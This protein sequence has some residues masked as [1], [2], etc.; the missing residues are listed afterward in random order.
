MTLGPVI[1]VAIG[2]IMTFAVMALVVS[3]VY[4]ALS[5]FFQTRS[6]NLRDGIGAL[7]NDPTFSGLAGRLFTHAAVHPLGD[8][9]PLD[10]Q[11]KGTLPTFVAPMQFAQALVEVIQT[12]D[13]VGKL[14][15]KDAIDR[16][17]DPQIKTFLSGVYA[18][19]DG[20]AARFHQEL[21]GWFDGAMERVRDNFKRNSQKWTFLIA[22]ILAVALN[23]DAFHMARAIWASPELVAQVKPLV[24]DNTKAMEDLA[25]L[26]AAGLPM[27]WSEVELGRLMAG[28]G[29][30]WLAWL[31]AKFVGCLFTASASML[32]A[33][34]WF[35]LLS[36]IRGSSV[37]PAP[38]AAPQSAP[39]PS[40]P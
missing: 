25:A 7:L 13:P 31:L 14:G 24:N 12:P 19:V 22:L 1:N 38:Q 23:I 6:T 32:G 9:K 21:A 28:G 4:Q 35:G 30:D 40:I 33:P 34:F 11:A 18:R 20:D 27:G 10:Q 16:I 36:Q 3:A 29:K 15:L 26:A 5:T 37:A 39:Q 8:G 17:T 2:M